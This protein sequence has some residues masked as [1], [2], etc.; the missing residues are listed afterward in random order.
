MQHDKTKP[1]IAPEIQQ[2]KGLKESDKG[3]A[4]T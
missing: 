2:S 3:N 1:H 4:P